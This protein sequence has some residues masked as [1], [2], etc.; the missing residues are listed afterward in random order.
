[1][2]SAE[3]HLPASYIPTLATLVSLAIYV[4]GHE[5]QKSKYNIMHNNARKKA[6]VL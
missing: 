2:N 6:D 4:T 1:M 3:N 5:N